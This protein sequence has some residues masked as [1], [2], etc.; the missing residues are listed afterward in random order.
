MLYC[1]TAL[2]LIVGLCVLYKNYKY[3]KHYYHYT[4]R[5]VCFEL[6]KVIDIPHPDFDRT[7]HKSFHYIRNKE[8]LMRVMVDWYNTLPPSISL[9][10]LGWDSTF[11]VNLAKELDFER[12]HYLITYHR[13]ITGLRHSPQLTRMDHHCHRNCHCVR[14]GTPLIPTLDTVVTDNVYIHRIRKNNRFRTPGP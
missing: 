1:V 11:V 8:L 4:P 2:A 3:Y 6:V 14:E 10:G 7:R 12:Y 9:R 5:E 13:Q